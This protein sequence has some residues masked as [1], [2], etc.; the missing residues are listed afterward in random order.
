MEAWGIVLSVAVACS[1]QTTTKVVKVGDDG[2][3]GASG[4][5]GMVGYGGAAG[6][7]GSAG[8]GMAD[9]GAAGRGGFSGSSAGGGFGAAGTGQGGIAGA[10]GF[11]AGQGGTSGACAG[12]VYEAEPR[13]LDMLIML[14]KSASMSLSNNRWGAVTSAIGTFVQEVG[15][16]G[17]GVGIG[18]FP[19]G[20]SATDPTDPGSCNAS[21]YARPDVPIDV[22]PAV[23][24]T[25]LDSLGRNQPGGGTPTAP[26]LQGALQYAMNWAVA[27]P[28]RQTIVVLATDGEPQGCS[29]NDLNTVSQ[30]AAAGAA[31]NPPINTY[32]IGIGNVQGLNQ[33]AQAGGTQQALVVQD[34]NASQQF[35]LA[36]RQIRGSSV[37]CRFSLPQTPKPIDFT[38]VN[39]AYTTVGGEVHVIYHVNGPADCRAD[40]G[41]W[42]YDTDAQGTPMAIELCPVSC[43][44]VTDGGGQI[45]VALGCTSV[46]PP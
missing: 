38:K 20:T 13:S 23:R 32:V 44:E 35:L 25:I 11:D 14:D 8:S 2:G 15:T 26:A 31:A 41:G 45:Q 10:F 12:L 19:T 7:G 3:S 30:I 18:Y 9:G 16:N 6:S 34:A 28:A 21:D 17:V 22:L 37:G 29:G 24:Q 39:V 4:A 27:H 1:G 40:V 46:P 5:A 33:V 36:L 43:R 42:Y